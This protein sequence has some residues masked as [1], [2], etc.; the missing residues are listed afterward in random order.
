MAA[1]LEQVAVEEEVPAANPMTIEE[2]LAFRATTIEQ[3]L[4]GVSKLGKTAKEVMSLNDEEGNEASAST[5]P[6][7]EVKPP[8][9]ILMEDIFEE[10]EGRE[11]ASAKPQEPNSLWI[12]RFHCGLRGS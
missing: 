9:K 6:R 10:F 7:E 1:V 4:E 8:T 2:V 12:K 11:A 3:V 5:V